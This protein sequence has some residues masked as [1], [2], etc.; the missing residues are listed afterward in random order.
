MIKYYVIILLYLYYHLLIKF[1]NLIHL[2]VLVNPLIIILN[3]LFHYLSLLFL[4]NIQGFINFI[5]I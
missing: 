2:I 1:N 3:D 5:L 4:I